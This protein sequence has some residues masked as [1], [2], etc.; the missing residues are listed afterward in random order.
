[1]K[2][3]AVKQFDNDYDVFYPMVKDKIVTDGKSFRDIL[4]SYC[5]TPNELTEIEQSQL[6][7][8]ILIPDLTLF[9]DFN[10]EKW[11]ANN[12]EIVVM[13]R[14]DESNTMYE[15]GE[16]I[17]QIA[18][19]NIPGFPCLV[20]KNNERLRVKNANTRSDETTYEFISDA[21]D[22]SKRIER[23]VTRD[24]YSDIDWDIPDDL[25]QYTSNLSDDLIKAWEVSK[26]I[27]QAYQR[28]YI[29]YGMDNTH[30]TGVINYDFQ[31]ELYRFRI[32][33]NVF[34]R[35]ST[36]GYDPVLGYTKKGGRATT[37][38]LRDKIW[39][40]GN[41]DFRFHI[42]RIVNNNLTELKEIP[43]SVPAKDVFTIE[44]IHLHHINPT[45]FRHSKNIYTVEPQYIKSKWIYPSKLE[46]NGSSA[47]L[48]GT[49]DLFA[50]S[51]N[52]LIRVEEF[53]QSTKKTETFTVQHQT[54]NKADIS[55]TN[56]NV[57]TEFGYSYTTTTSSTVSTETTEASDF[58][59]TID[60]HFKNPIIDAE[61]KVN[62]TYHL[63][64]SNGGAVVA[65]IIPKNVSGR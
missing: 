5:E 47:V 32:N 3:E 58:L 34:D 9:W 14:D 49:W 65:T 12:E 26:E 6:L 44:K 57:K 56:N 25:N 37:E 61:D 11:D 48:L 4:L 43:I 31:E 33:P 40:D 7:L 24:S 59:G 30:R 18:K 28:D 64:D 36:E 8:N 16:D 51:E 13:C 27:P 45:A 15:N 38:E 60:I 35:L 22:G 42:I 2:A 20:I 29:Y 52:I 55:S 50:N 53:D 17:G 10:A 63:F 19:G 23:P 54:V 21:F 46:S 62:G 41:F 1:M 39:S